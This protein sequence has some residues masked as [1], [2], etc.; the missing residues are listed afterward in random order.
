MSE[1]W[2]L[3]LQEPLKCRI[4]QAAVHNPNLKHCYMAS[5]LGRLP[6]IHLEITAGLGCSSVGGVLA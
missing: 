6:H 1:N 3:A 4:G 2:G 5:N